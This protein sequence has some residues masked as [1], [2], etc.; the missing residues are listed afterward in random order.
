M[1]KKNKLDIFLSV[2]FSSFIYKTVFMFLLLQ[3]YGL[4]DPCV[5]Y[6]VNSTVN[7]FG[8]NVSTQN[9]ASSNQTEHQRTT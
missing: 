3:M 2:E 6:S 7:F 4:T 8:I 5:S 9:D 1:F